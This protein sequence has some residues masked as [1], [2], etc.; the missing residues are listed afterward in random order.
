MRL[1]SG[2]SGLVHMH[3]TS[4]NHIYMSTVAVLHLVVA[5]TYH[6]DAYFARYILTGLSEGF[7]VGFSLSGSL[8]SAHRNIF[9]AYQHP[10]VVDE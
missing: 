6:Q 3:S 5:V 2:G 8:R 4:S 10:E 1:M 9:S 7:R